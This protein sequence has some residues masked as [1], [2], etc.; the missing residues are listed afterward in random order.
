MYNQPFQVLLHHLMLKISCLFAQILINC[1]GNQRSLSPNLQS[2]MN[3]DQNDENRQNSRNNNE[4]TNKRKK[5]NKY[6]KSHITK[7]KKNQYKNSKG[8][9]VKAQGILFKCKHCFITYQSTSSLNQ[10]IRIKHEKTLIYRCKRCSKNFSN[11]T[12]LRHHSYG[13][14]GERPYKCSKCDARFK[15]KANLKKHMNI[16][17][18]RG[19]IIEVECPE[20][21][22]LVDQSM[23]ECR[24]TPVQK[25]KRRRVV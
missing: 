19:A 6:V 1:S 18:H 11:L 21:E 16:K 25:Y 10:H 14:T 7:G 5:R 9:K 2:D 8:F 20:T 13:Y 4:H 17:K 3:V 24:G 12:S 22:A 23:M 15:Q